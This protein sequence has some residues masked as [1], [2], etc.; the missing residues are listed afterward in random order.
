[1]VQ[2][3]VV[4]PIHQK[5]DTLPRVLEALAKQE[6][7]GALEL[8]LVFDAC[9]D[10]SRQVAEASLAV[11]LFR[12]QILS[13]AERNPARVRNLGAEAA[14][15]DHLLF[16]DADVILPSQHIRTLRDHINTRGDG[17]LLTPVA[18]NAV[19]AD[20]LPLLAPL[21]QNWHALDNDSLLAWSQTWPEL[22][23]L[24]LT[25]AGDDGDLDHLPYPW[26]LGW[27]T[28]LCLPRGLFSSCGGF[29]DR[30]AGKGSEDLVLC[31][32]LWQAGMRFRLLVAAP[33]LHLPHARNRQAEVT[34][35]RQHEALLLS[36]APEP[37]VELLCAFDGGKA[38]AMAAFLQRVVDRPAR[39]RLE[40]AFRP[41]LPFDLWG[42]NAPV[43]LT[44]GLPP[45]AI[46]GGAVQRAWPFDRHEGTGD[47]PLFGFALPFAE[48]SLETVVVGGLFEVL[49]QRLRLRLLS[50]AQRIAS[51]VILV[52]LSAPLP[53]A[54]NL[55]GMA[56]T[57]DAPY[58][59]PYVPLRRDPRQYQ[60]AL[61]GHAGPYV[62]YSVTPQGSPNGE[63]R[64]GTTETR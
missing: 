53:M 63:S 55:D 37:D 64:A 23:D 39:T 42:I 45:A 48:R 11:Q 60:T 27:S 15:N 38:N 35:D 46:R 18:C 29:D 41:P 44:V 24:R 50:E 43:D 22:E 17:V 32:R 6:N 9:T 2:I 21:P 13:V 3:S 16:L 58:W 20:I 19:S 33:A 40:S 8:V 10:R 26:V 4:M 56:A 34:L 7:P 28:A 36:N 49:P 59:E 5:E 12:T 25:L 52:R 1:M 30:Y 31:R 57:L 62:S 61:I 14:T 54:R 47:L 51:R